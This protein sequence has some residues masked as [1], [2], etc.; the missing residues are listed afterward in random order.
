VD[1]E[2]GLPYLVMPVVEG[3]SLEQRIADDGPLPVIE[4]LRIGMQVASGLAAAH[5]QGLDLNQAKADGSLR[6]I[7]TA[8]R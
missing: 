5:A 4:V 1:E 2:R 3:K 6:V 7:R 8:Q